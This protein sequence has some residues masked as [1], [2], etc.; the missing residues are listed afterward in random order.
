M[1]SGQIGVS[2]KVSLVERESLK[3]V[4]LTFF[5]D[6]KCYMLDDSIVTWE[7]ANHSC[8]S[9]GG[10]LLRI[11]NQIEQGT[12]Y[13]T[14]WL[15]T[16]FF[17]CCFKLFNFV[18][19]DYVMSL[20]NSNIN[21]LWIDFNRIESETFRYTNSVPV[22]YTKWDKNQPTV[23]H[24]NTRI[25][26]EVGTTRFRVGPFLKLLVKFTVYQLSA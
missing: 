26:G 17:L 3:Y 8:H 5:S 2:T 22:T 13:Q 15:C 9:N 24:D 12:Y 1:I 14:D 25:Q 23:L 7:L 16:F 19:K 10:S 4:K 11:Q 6:N 21:S 20:I 18:F